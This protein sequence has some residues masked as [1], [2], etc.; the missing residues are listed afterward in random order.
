MTTAPPPLQNNYANFD[1]TAI[2][3]MAMGSMISNQMTSLL[4]STEGFSINKIIKL[5][6][7]MSIDEIKKNLL[8][9][10]KK[11]LAF[12]QS[13][14]VSTYIYL[15]QIMTD[16]TYTHK[17]DKITCITDIGPPPAIINN[18]T[19]KFE[20]S[21][22]FMK[23]MMQHIKTNGQYKKTNVYIMNIENFDKTM[24][25]E[26]WY[27]IIVPFEDVVLCID[28]VLNFT[29]EEVKGK[30]TLHSYSS[31]IPGKITDYSK[32]SCLADMMTDCKLKQMLRKVNSDQFEECTIFDIN[33]YI[34]N[35][36][37][38]IKA[39][40]TY[41]EAGF[42]SFL[43]SKIPSL[44]AWKVMN[45]LMILH[46]LWSDCAD[47]INNSFYTT[48]KT[49]KI[50]GTIELPINPEDAQ[51]MC[52][53]YSIYN[54]ASQALKNYIKCIKTIVDINVPIL[55][56]CDD[57]QS[58]KYINNFIKY[59]TEISGGV[60]SAA[61]TKIIDIS[62]YSAEYDNDHLYEY[63]RRFISSINII[64]PKVLCAEVK[65]Y[66]I[67]VKD[68]IIE[69]KK[70]NPLYNSYMKH[71]AS[72]EKICVDPAFKMNTVI[73]ESIA[74]YIRRGQPD[75]YIA[76][77][78]VSREIVCTESMTI[79]RGFDSLY[80]RESDQRK[81][82]HSLE[83]FKENKKL[84]KQFGLPDKLG[85]MLHGL[86]GTGKTSTIHSIATYLNKNIYCV[87]FKTIKC[88][89][90]F[91]L[92]VDYICHH[93]VTGGILTFEDID[94]MSNVMHERTD[95]DMI[96]SDL[97]LDYILNV[98]QGSMTPAGIVF[99]ATTNH[100]ERLDKALYRPGRFDVNIDMKKCDHY[101]IRQIYK[102]MK[103][104]DIPEE[105]L[106]SISEDEWEPA[107]IIDQ[108]RLS[109]ICDYSDEEIL[110]PFT[111]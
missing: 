94:A 86:A 17:K 1:S 25:A 98:F 36:R 32:L 3:N 12:M 7:V 20:P 76:I 93:C 6:T 102:T 37:T 44:N 11:F 54:H 45:E 46:L 52:C 58:M 39:K 55:K 75:E 64:A 19:V 73:Q 49:I 77:D 70:P 85:I 33:L 60:I 88:N 5:L 63:Y 59:S 10:F 95:T 111:F 34:I 90:D 38:K 67:S 48:K 47:M 30:T 16:Y 31:I 81:L 57:C 97:T 53:S 22:E 82:L 91:Q 27:D 56:L 26:V 2:I 42:I 89:S 8:E 83:L 100:I 72:I 35:E 41:I 15:N 29:F 9:W 103:S 40:N 105:L 4:N 14:S 51:F 108:I 109:L 71:K 21:L 24:T 66:I 92:I 65:S 78:K 61:Q 106:S 107:K 62:I 87:N 110:A 99:I 18:I 79:D 80:L 69:D 28:H 68:T 84:M 74:D 104:R 43:L 13:K 23:L 50:F 96:S 101:Q